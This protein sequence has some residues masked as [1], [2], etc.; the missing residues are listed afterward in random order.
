V[1]NETHPSRLTTEGSPEERSGGAG[2]NGGGGGGVGGVG[3]VGPC[4]MGQEVEEEE[5]LL[6]WTARK[7][8]FD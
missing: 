6:V 7:P 4:T 5:T 1:K 2:A 8:Y 3:G